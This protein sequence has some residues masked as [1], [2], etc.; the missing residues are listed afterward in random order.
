MIW[1][2]R[3]LGSGF[4]SS[5][6]C[7]ATGATHT[8][9]S[10][11]RTRRRGMHIKPSSFTDTIAPVIIAPRLFYTDEQGK[12]NDWS[13][14]LTPPPPNPNGEG[15]TLE[16]DILFATKTGHLVL[17]RTG[18]PTSPDVPTY[19]TS[20]VVLALARAVRCFE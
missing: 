7:A 11:Q 3:M 13:W 5:E 15:T 20:E 18:P 1:S 16:P 17:P 19:P 4:L 2:R 12:G 10:N 14:S 6:D 8:D 9:N